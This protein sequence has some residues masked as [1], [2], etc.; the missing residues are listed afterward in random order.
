MEIKQSQV[1]PNNCIM[2]VRLSDNMVMENWIGKIS[3]F[4]RSHKIRDLSIGSLLSSPKSEDKDV[5]LSWKE[6]GQHFIFNSDLSSFIFEPETI[7]SSVVNFGLIAIFLICQEQK[8]CFL[9]LLLP[10]VRLGSIFHS[11]HGITSTH[12]KIY[13]L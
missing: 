10:S 8:F 4:S 6:K 5:Q 3:S 9:V 11:I 13:K 2:W 1:I 7:F 12:I